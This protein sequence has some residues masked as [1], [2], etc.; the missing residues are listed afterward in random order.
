MLTLTARTPGGKPANV[1]HTTQN[2]KSMHRALQ[3]YAVDGAVQ[4]GSRLTDLSV[5]TATTS[6]A[7]FQAQHGASIGTNCS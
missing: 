6:T 7:I 3:R 1:D 4:L 5:E 2:G